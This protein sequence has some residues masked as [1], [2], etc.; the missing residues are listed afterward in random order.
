MEVQ[1]V[2]LVFPKTYGF[3][4]EARADRLKR[5]AKHGLDTDRLLVLEITYVV[6]YTRDLDP[7]L[8]LT[9]FLLVPKESSYFRVL[10][11][12]E[13]YVSNAPAVD[14]EDTILHES[15]HLKEDEEALRKGLLVGAHE[16]YDEIEERIGETVR[17][18][19]R[20]KYGRAVDRVGNQ[21][22]AYAIREQSR[23]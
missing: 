17:R 16:S 14:L 9:S 23:R 15:I 5:L 18:A 3:I 10:V 19:L 13:N 22:F 4:R 11:F 1:G 7:A 12:T 20:V 21:S 6:T 8:A 2:A